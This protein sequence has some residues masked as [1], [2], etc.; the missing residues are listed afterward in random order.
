[1]NGLNVVLRARQ[2]WAADPLSVITG[3][4]GGRS[5]P[6]ARF[7][8]SA[9]NPASSGR[10]N[11]HHRPGPAVRPA[12]P[13]CTRRSVQP[14]RHA[15]RDPHGQ[16][17][18]SAAAT[19]T[20]RATP[21]T[22]RQAP[23]SHRHASPS[24]SDAISKPTS[25][26]DHASFSSARA[27]RNSS[28]RWVA[29]SRHRGRIRSTRE[30]SSELVPHRSDT[31]SRSLSSLAATGSREAPV[32]EPDRNDTRSFFVS[33][34]SAPSGSTSSNATLPLALA[35]PPTS[36]AGRPVSSRLTSRPTGHCPAT[37]QTACDG[38]RSRCGPPAI[39]PRPSAAG[40][41]PS[42]LALP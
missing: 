22:P 20:S 23:F 37:C 18:Q 38:D 25:S 5:R 31:R 15:D 27:Y 10:Q 40:R 28:S 19:G 16:V 33:P 42:W 2:Q 29:E 8:T 6:I 4:S 17:A 41:T 39:H 13:P 11:H 24:S 32:S 26:P 9:I 34:S 7:R 12:A 3:N 35:R 30:P 21:A 1:M 14:V 36:T